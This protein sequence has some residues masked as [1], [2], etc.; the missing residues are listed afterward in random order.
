MYVV[1]G[2]NPESECAIQ[3]ADDGNSGMMIWLK[4]IKAAV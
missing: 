2:F 4:I 1:I 3:D